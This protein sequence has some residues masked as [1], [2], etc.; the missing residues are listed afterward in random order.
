MEAQAAGLPVITDNHSGAIDRLSDGGG[1]LCNNFDE[2]ISAMK[3]INSP[4]RR[5]LFGIAS[6][7]NADYNYNPELWISEIT[8]G[9][10]D[11]KCA[12][13]AEEEDVCRQAEA[14][15]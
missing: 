4:E 1:Y 7:R 14:G 6:R 5:E 9:S 13:I 3:H 11:G 8:G 12:R 2:H 10:D 15:I